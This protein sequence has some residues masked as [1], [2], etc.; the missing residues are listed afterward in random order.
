MES[1]R[2]TFDKSRIL[3]V[4]P[5]GIEYRD[6]AER[7][8][9]IDFDGCGGGEGNRY[10]YVG[11]RD[12]SADPPCFEFPTVPPTRF[13]FGSAAAEGGHGSGDWYQDFVWLETQIR[14]AG[15]MTVDLA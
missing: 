1:K 2:V 5:R 6:D 10:R 13:V 11:S 9:L 14:K 7:D 8:C 12:F 15:W 3:S 4:T